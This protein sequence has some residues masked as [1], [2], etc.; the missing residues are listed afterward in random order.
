MKE[1]LLLTRAGCDRRTLQYL[2]QGRRITTDV[3]DNIVNF[4][5]AERARR[6]KAAAESGG[7]AEDKPGTTPEEHSDG[8]R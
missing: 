1:T 3:H 4:M 7:A 6:A 2:R 8:E 5:A